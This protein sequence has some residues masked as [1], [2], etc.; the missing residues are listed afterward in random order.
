MPQEGLT[1]W[2]GVA[3]DGAIS[4]QVL[5]GHL[6]D[7]ATVLSGTDRLPVYRSRSEL[8]SAFYLFFLVDPSR[9]FI[10]VIFLSFLFLLSALEG[11]GG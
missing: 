8:L 3:L 4:I 5:H 2:G 6:G 9:P 10:I 11:I 7:C 1:L